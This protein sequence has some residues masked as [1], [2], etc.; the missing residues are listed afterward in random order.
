MT[1]VFRLHP[2]CYD[3]EM[4]QA[5]HDE[6]DHDAL[7]FKKLHIIRETAQSKALNHLSRPAV[8]I[9]PSGMCEGG[10]VLHHLR[11]R[12]GDPNTTVMFVGYQGQHTLGR[13]LLDGQSPVN[14]FGEP[15][16]VRA[17]IVRADTYSAH[18]DRDELLA[19]YDRLS[20]GGHPQRTFLV[21]GEPEA[22]ES[23]AKAL[24]ARGAPRVDIP[25]PGARFRL[26]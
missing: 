4:R 6:S 2:E 8:I 17:R 9:S 25:A 20:A 5:I 7:G 1:Q 12:L 19:W 15:H 10:R 13:K 18:A 23:L 22:Q 21:H 26:G 14:I 11:N 3:E 16:E 24:E